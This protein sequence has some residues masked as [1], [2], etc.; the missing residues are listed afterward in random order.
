MDGNAAPT[1]VRDAKRDHGVMLRRRIRIRFRKID[2][3]RQISHLD[4][5]RTMER[6]FR[7]AGL[8]L[9]MSEGF[10]P[11]PRMSFPSAL[12]VGIAGLDEVME[13]ELNEDRSA[14]AIQALLVQHAPPGLEMVSVESLADGAPK[15]LVAR[16][17]LEMPVPTER[18]AA[19]RENIARLMAETT[20][21]VDRGTTHNPI[22]LRPYLE[23]L[24]LDEGTLRIQL[25][26]TQQG[27]GRPR[28]VLVALGLEDLEQQGYHLTRTNVELEA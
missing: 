1:H 9:G 27:T 19:A 16:V 5:I 26:V 13:V 2:D 20:H 8:Q 11:K 21:P 12:A 28:E 23:E 10:H 4:L 24:T 7:R 22:D 18:Q 14:E 25:R 3:V 6:L 15:P 17:R